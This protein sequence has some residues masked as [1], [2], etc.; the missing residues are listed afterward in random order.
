MGP[1]T[2]LDFRVATFAQQPRTHQNEG[3]IKWGSYIPTGRAS[4]GCNSS[5]PNPWMPRVHEGYDSQN[6]DRSRAVAWI[7]NYDGAVNCL[8]A[9][10]F[11]IR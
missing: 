3:K 8:S 4:T 11:Q 2:H 6:I 9:V 5:P 1:P 7:V 10:D